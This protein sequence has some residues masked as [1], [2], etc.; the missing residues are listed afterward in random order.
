M[1]TY[2]YDVTIKEDGTLDLH[3]KI[4]EIKGKRVRVMVVEPYTD[5]KNLTTEEII[6]VTDKDWIEWHSPEEDI[7]DEYRKYLSER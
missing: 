2:S 7:Y 1:K 3:T 6:K 4:P 5:E